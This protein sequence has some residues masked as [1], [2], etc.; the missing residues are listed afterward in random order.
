MADLIEI[1]GG[2]L[3][4]AINPF[5]AELTHLRDAQGREL[6]TD[7]DPKF[8]TGHAPLLFPFVGRLNGDML[9]LD[10]AEYPMKQ[11][12]FARRH[13]FALVNHDAASAHF[14]LVDDAE[15]R[16]VYPFA[17]A[18]DATYSIAGATLTVAIAITNRG[19]V[20]MPASFG[21]HPA[22][23]WPLPYGAPR[24]DHRIVFAADQPGTLVELNDGLATSADRASP[25]DGRVLHLKEGLF[26][27]DALIWNGLASRSVRYGASTGPQLDVAFDADK[28]GIWSKPGAARF[29]CIEP[30][31]GI[32]DP[33]GHTGDFRDKPGVFE[34]APGG[35]WSCQLRVTLT[36]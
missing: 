29:V 10:G 12:G 34:I 35:T 30:W 14:R 33:A 31:H 27:D 28:L 19:D 23:A 16:A 36:A 20:A 6:M 5:G 18:L 1:K 13:N 25:L 32:A 8:W 15:T 17:F 2:G 21:F 9:R 11:H 3:S 7:A 22:F 4:A 24:E 26:D